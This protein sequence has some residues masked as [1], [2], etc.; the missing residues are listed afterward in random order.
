MKTLNKLAYA[1]A[2]VVGVSGVQAQEHNLKMATIAPGT[3]AYLAMTTMATLVNQNLDSVNIQ[4]DATGAATKHMIEVAQGKLDMAMTSPTIYNFMKKGIIM[5]SKLEDPAALAE[6]LQLVYWFPL[7]QYH[8]VTYADSNIKTP[9]DLKGKKIFLGPPGGGAYAAA[10]TWVKIISGYEPGE[11]FDA[12]KAS[13]SSAQQGFQDRQFDVYIISGIAPF[14]LV[15]QLSLTSD[16][17]LIGLS[18]DEFEANQAAQDFVF[19][20]Q[21][22]E[23]GIIPAGIYGDG[24]V[25]TEDVYTLGAVVGITARKDL[26]ADMIYDI[27]KTYW[28][29]SKEAMQTNPWL[30]DVTLEYG[31]QDGGMSLHPGALRYYEEIGLEIPDGSR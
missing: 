20:V 7:G 8:I 9:A 19:T 25:N 30:K 16:L 29:A 13:W 6:N 12:V 4:V 21:G 23:L 11:D 2:F 24:V 27:T 10:K 28:E 22:E 26:D 31:V 15:E 17:R 5:Y 14:P 1:A 3:S 18:K